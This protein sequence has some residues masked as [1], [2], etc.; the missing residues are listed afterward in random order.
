LSSVALVFFLNLL[1]NIS[2]SIFIRLRLDEIHTV[3]IK[4]NNNNR[5]SFKICGSEKNRFVIRLF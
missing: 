1:F 3:A 2:I 5:S 4:L